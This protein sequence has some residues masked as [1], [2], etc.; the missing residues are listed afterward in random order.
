MQFLEILKSLYHND[1]ARNGTLFSFF[2]FLN[3]GL[4]FILLIIIAGLLTP[5]GYGHLNIFN[6][7]ITLISYFICFNSIG[8]ISINFFTKYNDFNKTIN[9]IVILTGLCSTLLYVLITLLHKQL[10]V[11]TGLT[12]KF[13]I[14]ALLYCALNVIVQI[15]LE[16]W[17]IQEK[18]VRYGL[19]TTIFATSNFLLTIIFILFL[20]KDWSGRIYAQLIVIFFF[21][22]YS[23]FFLIKN[24]YLLKDP[25]SKRDF[26]DC[27]KFGVPLIPH[28]ISYWLRQG[29]DRIIINTYHSTAFAGL[30][31]FSFNIAS[32]I[33]ILGD[34]FNATNSVFIYKN[35]SGNAQNPETIRKLRKQT[36]IMIIFFAIVTVLIYALAIIFIPIILPQYE[37]AKPFLIWQCLGCFFQCVY[38]QFVNYIFFF[39]KTKVL[40]SITFTTSVIHAILSL[41]LTKYS[42][43][44]TAYISTISSFI[45]MICVYFYSRK[46]YKII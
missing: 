45:I 36:F 32:V 37:D 10:E 21:F 6:L 17:R 42:I 46:L 40:M 41:I 18:V 22:I 16:I 29:L 9:T 33:Q 2:S 35:L 23:S 4:G 34:S 20:H 31:S 25:P 28:D 30:F 7:T 12:Y 38:L 24:Q 8:L 43:M 13:Q 26:I 19:Y 44:Y 27:C 5:D 14:A 39:K 15:N 1:T 11:W 3:K